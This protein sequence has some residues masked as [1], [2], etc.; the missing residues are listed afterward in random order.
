MADRPASIEDLGPNAGLVDEMYRL[1]RDNPE[2]VSPGWRDFF[3]DY[4]P[5]AEPPAPAPT[6]ARR[7]PGPAP[8]S[9]PH[10]LPRRHPSAPKAAGPDAPVTLDGEQAAPLRGASARVVQNME[11]SLAVPTATSVRA[12]PAKLLEVN[13]QILNNQLARTRGGKVSFT[14]L[15]GFAVVRALQRTPHMNASYGVTDGKPS[16]VRHEH[17]N[18][19]LAID[20]Q[21]SDG[22]RTLLVPNI[23]NADT[24]DFAAFHAAYEDLVRRART[25]KLTPD[26]F[27]GTTVS[28]T[29]PGT[30]GTM[31]SVPRLMPGQGVIVGVGAIVYP[32]EY[33][34]ADPQTLADIGVS[35][36]VTLTSTYDHR[37]IQGAESGEF[38]A[39]MHDLLL[40]GDEFYDELFASFGVPYEPAR[41]SPDRKPLEGS[42]E[43]A[44]K[45]IAVQQL[46]NMYRVR[47]HLIANLDPLGLKEPKT[48]EELDPNHWGLTIWDLDR[49]FPTGGLAGR[50]TMKLRD[51][52]GLLRNAYARTI[53]VEYMHIQEPDQKAWIQEQVEGVHVDATP[54]DKRRILS[55]LNGAEAFERF[56]HTK[57]LGQK[58][59]SLEGAETLIPMLEFLLDAR[60]MPA[61]RNS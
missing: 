53:G 56:L 11:A 54:E 25:N 38:L 14:H 40:G 4:Q 44:H 29:N 10:P 52:L 17:V 55:A 46:I 12:V 20:Q 43:A 7:R 26:D 57:F 49:E 47:G 22:T 9:R 27:A 42:A 16:V 37:I 15:I 19:G 33:E 41:W 30:I 23:K 48:H 28:I 8:P 35:K 59:F 61:S 18:L 32:P 5:R 45:I 36:V 21:K 24:L 39:T 31:H 50:A 60:P 1:Y 2:A 51:I 58:R 34:G 3:A 6:S 13:R